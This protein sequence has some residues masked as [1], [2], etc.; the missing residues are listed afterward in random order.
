MSAAWKSVLGRKCQSINQSINQSNQLFKSDKTCP[1]ERQEGLLDV[2]NETL[3]PLGPQTNWGS[4]PVTPVCRPTPTMNPAPALGTFFVGHTT[5]FQR[6]PNIAIYRTFNMW[7]ECLS[8]A[9]RAVGYIVSCRPNTGCS[10]LVRRLVMLC[11]PACASCRALVNSSKIGRQTRLT[12]SASTRWKQSLVGCRQLN[13]LYCT[14]EFT[15]WKL[16]IFMHKH[17]YSQSMERVPAE[18]PTFKHY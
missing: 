12:K 11:Q 14:E 5:R 4:S 17:K 8:D 3:R 16:F 1:W 2:S 18:N 9:D 15:L 10:W 7:S 13:N 6:R